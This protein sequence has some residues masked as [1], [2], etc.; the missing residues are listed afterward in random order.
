MKL[1]SK[2]EENLT[3]ILEEVLISAVLLRLKISTNNAE[4]NAPT[5][6]AMFCR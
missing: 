6:T 1:A 5:E 2:F 4:P 3:K